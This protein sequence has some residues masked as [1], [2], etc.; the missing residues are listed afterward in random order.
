MDGE[1]VKGRGCGNRRGERWMQGRG[2]SLYPRPRLGGRIWGLP[3]GG[4]EAERKEEKRAVLGSRNGS[5]HPI[6]STL[7][8]RSARL[9]KIKYKISLADLVSVMLVGWCMT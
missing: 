9:K 2:L 3:E 8:G 5:P 4:R 1:G 7:A 6:E